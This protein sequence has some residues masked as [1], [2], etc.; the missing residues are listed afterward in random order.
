MALAA[1]DVMHL[2]SL[3]DKLQIVRD[4]TKSVV[5]GYR[6][7]L[8]LWGEGGIG[9]SYSVLSELER[10]K[11]DYVLH[12]S[13]LTG[14]G[15]FDLLREHPDQVHVLEDCEPLFADKNACG[16]L[17][18][19]LW[20]QTNA[21]H[22]QERPVTWRTFYEQ[23]SFTFQGGLIFIGNRP[24]DSVVE[25][26]A[27]Q[28]RIPTLQLTTTNQELAALMRSVSDEGF[29]VLLQKR[30]LKSMS[31][32]QCHE[33]CEYLIREI[34]SLSRNL[35]MRLLVN[36]FRD[37]LQYEDGETLTHWKN[38]VQ[39]ELKQQVVVPEPRS[40]RLARE[41]QIALEIAAMPDLSSADRERLFT[42]RT[43]TSGRGYRRRLQETRH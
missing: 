16:V 2:D 22:R 34:H 19:A 38:L 13:R 35:D 33:V 18:S 27:L 20:G 28:T 30:D 42:E 3:E 26:R 5:R 40:E 12:N 23:L 10:L 29:R 31:P 1:D 43:G 8:H 14:R 7:G 6:N 11:A 37:Y 17:R 21:Q 25:L 9:K 36:S 15:L 41:R 39:S 4:R 32:A 24:L